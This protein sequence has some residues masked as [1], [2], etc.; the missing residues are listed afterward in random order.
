[1][2]PAVKAAPMSWLGAGSFFLMVPLSKYST[3]QILNIDN[4]IRPNDV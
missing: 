3:L 4:Q 2:N 1:M